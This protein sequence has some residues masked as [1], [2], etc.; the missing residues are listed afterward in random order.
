M[1]TTKTTAIFLHFYPD[2]SLVAKG[3][4][5]AKCNA[6]TISIH[7][8]FILATDTTT[9]QQNFDKHKVLGVLNDDIATIVSSE[10]PHKLSQDRESFLGVVRAV[11]AED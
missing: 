2:P 5:L 6:E 9:K 1:V 7:P 3:R 11:S 10:A 8:F 4:P